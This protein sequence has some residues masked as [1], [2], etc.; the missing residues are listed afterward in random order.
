MEFYIR[1]KIFLHFLS[2]N[3]EES[4]LLYKDDI[5]VYKETYPIYSFNQSFSKDKNILQILNIQ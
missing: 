3:W 5:D 2:I 1:M 4:F